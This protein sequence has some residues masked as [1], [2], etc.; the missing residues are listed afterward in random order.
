MTPDIEVIR[1]VRA[2]EIRDF[3]WDTA[4][5][6]GEASNP[7]GGVRQTVR[8][9]ESDSRE[10]WVPEVLNSATDDIYIEGEGW[11]AL[12]GFSGQ[13]AYNGAVLHPSEYM[14][15]GLARHMLENP[16]VYAI[17]E[18]REEDGTLPDSALIGWVVLRKIEED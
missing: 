1:I 12:K 11:E 5:E 6:I 9:V 2:V 14:G 8:R 3:P 15:G 18:V 17:T 10:F 4:V 13:H 16:G 7:I